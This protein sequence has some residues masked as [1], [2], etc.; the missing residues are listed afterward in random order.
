MLKKLKLALLWLLI[1]PLTAQAE[2]CEQ[3]RLPNLADTMKTVD[4][5]DADFSYCKSHVNM[6]FLIW[7]GIGCSK[8]LNILED[9]AKKLNALGLNPPHNP[10]SASDVIDV[11]VVDMAY[12]GESLEKTQQAALKAC[13]RLE[14]REKRGEVIHW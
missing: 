4:I 5:L 2:F 6:A 1:L 13:R 12:A 14:A 3:G 8:D 11:R 10:H 9:K 7:A